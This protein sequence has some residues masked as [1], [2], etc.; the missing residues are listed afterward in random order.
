MIGV[1]SLSLPEHLFFV[2]SNHHDTP[3]PEVRVRDVEVCRNQQRENVDEDFGGE[4]LNGAL[5]A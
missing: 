3:T 1:K 4:G 2:A 5:M